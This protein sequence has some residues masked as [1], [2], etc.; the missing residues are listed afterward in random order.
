M[1]LFSSPAAIKKYFERNASWCMSCLNFDKVA[2]IWNEPNS[3]VLALN[4]YLDFKNQ[5]DDEGTPKIIDKFIEESCRHSNFSAFVI[6]SSL[7]SY[8]F[9]VC[10]DLYCFSVFS[11]RFFALLCIF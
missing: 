4:Y 3:V 10:I 2:K 7:L 8:F 5:P 1:V 6:R 9:V 11:A